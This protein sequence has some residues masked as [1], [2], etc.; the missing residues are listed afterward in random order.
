M[1]ITKLK[2]LSLVPT[3]SHI[4]SLVAVSLLSWFFLFLSLL[5]AALWLAAEQNQRLTLWKFLA[6]KSSILIAEWELLET[7][8]RKPTPSLLIIQL[9][10]EMFNTGIVGNA[11]LNDISMMTKD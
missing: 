3:V 4:S 10:V 2:S 9:R 1:S 6:M 11:N 8:V 5:F 7:Q